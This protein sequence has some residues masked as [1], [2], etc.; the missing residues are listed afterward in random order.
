M[1]SNT[2]AR[3]D[4]DGS[5]SKEGD[6]HL[7]DAFF[8]IQ[9]LQKSG[10]DTVLRGASLQQSQEVDTQYTD[11]LRNFLFAAPPEGSKCPMRGILRFANGAFPALD[12]GSRNIQEEEIMD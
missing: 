3:R 12:L 1:I 7:R 2:I 4:H 10:I 11:G 5:E 8:N 9:I 6:I